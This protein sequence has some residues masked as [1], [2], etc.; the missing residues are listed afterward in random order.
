MLLAD[1]RRIAA[2]ELKLQQREAAGRPGGRERSALQRVRAEAEASAARRLA[3][4]PA[5]NYPGELPVSARIDEIR[6]AI[7]ANQVIIVCGDTGSGKTTQLPKACLQAGRG[8]AGLI[9]HAQPR[10]IAARAVAARLADELGVAPGT[11]VGFKIRLAESGNDDSLIRVM[12]DGILL[13]EIQGDPELLRYDTIIIDEAHERSLN[14]DFLL[15]YLKRLLPRRPDLRVIITSATI[16][17]QGFS[18]FFD[19]APVIEVSGRSYPIET[20]FRPLGAD[21]DDDLDPGLIPGIAAALDEL[22]SDSATRGDVLVF[23]PGEREIR[24]TA[25]YLSGRSQALEILPLYS[26]LG[27]AEQQKIFARGAR[28]RVVLTTNVAETSITVPGITAVIDSG[29]AR[30]GRYSP[31]SKILRLP[32]EPISQA[33]A[34]QRK[35]RCG[36]VGP[37]V[38]I[39][40][41]A[42]EDFNNREAF[43]P[44]EVLRTNL[45]R[46][47]LQMEVLG[48][49][50]LEEFPF[51][52]PPDHR[53]ISDGYRLL[54]ELEALD[55]DRR[56][57]ALG[58]NMARLPVDPRLARMLT[59]AP[60]HAALAEMLTLVAFLSIQDPR[61]RPAGMQ[62]AADEKHAQFADA[63]SDYNTLLKLWAA[64]RETR[65][66]KSSN[67]AR[68]WCREQFLS[69][70]RMREWDE[71]RA[72]L[73]QITQ[74]LGWREGTTTA[75]E[76]GIHRSV[77]SGLLG[78][79]GERTEQG[80]YLGPR[81]MRFTV[82]PG[83]AVRKQ[84]P[85]W[86]MAGS[87]VETSR[88]YARLVAAIEPAWI[89]AAA[90]HLVKRSYSEPE[91]QPER[92]MVSALET[93]SLYG[94]ILSA[95]RRVNFG[96]VEPAAAREIFVREALLHERCQLQGRFR[97]ANLRTRQRLEAAEAR[98]RRR[99]DLLDE[100]RVMAWFLARVP[101]AVHDLRG[102]ERWR[103]EAEV[104][105]WLEYSADDIVPPDVIWPDAAQF[106]GHWSLAD[107]ALRLRYRFDPEDAQDG[108]TLEVPLP[109]LG[110]LNSRDIDWWIP[111]WRHERLTDMIR[112]L[113]KPVRRRLV[114]APETAAA[115]LAAL[116]ATGPF[117][118]QVAA[119]L[120]QHGTV[121][122]SADELRAVGLAPWLTPG[123]T[124]IDG[125]GRPLGQGRD[126]AQLQH[127]LA[128]ERHAALQEASP[129]PGLQSMTTWDC[130]E[131]ARSTRIKRGGLT[132]EVFPAL[133]DRGDA[134]AL[135]VS[136]SS[137]LAEQKHRAGVRR[138]LSIALASPLAHARRACAADRELALLL[139][140]VASLKEFAEQ[141]CDRAVERA[142]LADGG[143]LPRSAADFEL[144]CER[145]RGEVYE[146]ARRIL[147]TV[148]MALKVAH[149]IRRELAALGKI[150]DR[151]S[152]ED[153]QR[154]LAWLLGADFVAASED[155][156]LHELPRLLKG[157]KGRLEKLRG[158]SDLR[159]QQDMRRWLDIIAQE[160]QGAAKAGQAP[161]EALRKLHWMVAEYGVSLFAQAL[162]TRLPVSAQRLTRQLE[163]VRAA[164]GG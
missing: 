160:E 3:S 55:E 43:T 111:G 150:A 109:L 57:T 1:Q 96:L 67:Q 84:A 68:R 123:F 13:A 58:R 85:R 130:G 162:G 103:R 113:P 128:A 116:P 65:K 78:A 39:R 157:L 87:I 64:W 62:Q 7:E 51:L 151:A 38:C 104:P 117:L 41:Y 129:A 17:P 125:Q 127:Q 91:W 153:C 60:R 126:L 69:A 56:L 148:T 131:L 159:A 36:R 135:V 144:A 115:C 27:W 83:T 133:E 26:R 2:L 77:L 75:S 19:A 15:G 52:D 73:R 6:R 34:E 147:K 90:H 54:V 24:D 25:E 122:V 141:L 22:A 61:E 98:L 59:E 50:A 139:Q 44:P 81:G 146:E 40:L 28:R 118:E 71:L 106:P 155:P 33:S 161:G 164:P 134:V 31:R 145:G 108:A 29:L 46:V 97:A 95:G 102:F 156:W 10:R 82:A 4:V 163:Q 124:V 9:G 154:Q 105:G 107:Q 21:E 94:L 70:L 45:A 80:D 93:V 53:L 149:D 12:T 143:A 114:P 8:Q 32:I 74:E 101:A 120:S 63:R 16:D 86:I 140:P 158:A 152:V 88:V 76:E 72:Q 37:G 11:T 66:D 119:W 121:E 30:I 136:D 110:A 142:C 5:L 47:I 132:L 137:A 100:E 99:G 18:R 138:L 14:I 20:R 79:I 42:E 49:G 112:G 23:L 92:G 48:L 89:E 35:G